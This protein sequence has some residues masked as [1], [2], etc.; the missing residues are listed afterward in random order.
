MRGC[1]ALILHAHL[2]WVR[3][4]EHERFLEE[5]WLF[6]ATVETY[7]PLLQLLARWQAD[8]VQPHLTLSVSPTLC[9]MLRDSLLQERFVRRC[10]LLVELAEKE[11]HR[12]LWQPAFRALA[13]HC[14]EQ[15]AGI[16]RTYESWQRDLVQAFRYF[17]EAGQLEVITTAATHAVLPLLADHPPSLRGQIA[18][19]AAV[20]REYFGRAP[21]GFWLPECA[22]SE[23]VEPHLLEHGFRWCVVESHGLLHATPRPRVGTAA[24]VVTPQGLAVF[25]RDAASAQHVWSRE[26]GYPGDPRY[27][28]FYRDVG[29]DLDF[30]Y[31]Q[32]YLPSPEHRGF[33]GLKYYAITSA[34]PEKRV[35][36]VAAARL[37][38]QGHAA[39][40]IQARQEHLGQ[41]AAQP[42]TAPVLTAPYDAELFGHWWYEGWWFLDAVVRAIV[43][44][45]PFQLI[46]PSEYL[47]QHPTQ[48]IARP[49]ASS[50]GEQG[51]WQ[52]WLDAAN[53]W[54]YP[55]LNLAQ[56][57]MTDLART[58]HRPTGR[59]AL[60][61]R[62][63]AQELLL[64][65][66]SDWPFILRAGHNAP[67]ARQRLEDHLR[68]F[69]TLR[70]QLT[71]RRIDATD[72]DALAA[73]DLAFPNLDWRH[74]R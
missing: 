3:H 10:K 58:H 22:Y 15:L 31:V 5:S 37:A 69:E 11:I 32:P 51:H 44:E 57:Q 43:Q 63:A 66:A 65:Q 73:Q 42:A 30:D 39:H 41:L 34:S 24:P 29:Y 70:D 47:R 74:W 12:T 55:Q 64:A 67:Y 56:H 2:P 18:T 21:N 49:A 13:E 6:E 59:T 71:A 61:L 4:P 53:A 38:V 26:G 48:Q 35:Y 1:L 40:F 17:Q 16:L 36:D 54:I 46:T 62:L 72:L 50:W 27:R 20:Y 52:V 14:R 28:D 45:N 9:A 60:A 19:A 8:G 25:G 33:T 68:R 23:A 7:V